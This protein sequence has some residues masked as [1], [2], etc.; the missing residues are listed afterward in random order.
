ME[1]L[2]RRDMHVASM[3]P[4]RIV[5]LACGRNRREEPGLPGTSGQLSFRVKPATYG[6]VSSKGALEANQHEVRMARLEIHTNALFHLPADSASMP[7]SC[8]GRHQRRPLASRGR[9]V[10]III[11]SCSRYHVAEVGR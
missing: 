6:Q 3:S 7:W 4:P 2:R 9:C 11:S 1:R 8:Q 10:A 5:G